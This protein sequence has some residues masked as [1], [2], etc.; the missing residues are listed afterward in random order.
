MPDGGYAAVY[1]DGVK[2][3]SPIIGALLTPALSWDNVQAMALAFNQAGSTDPDKVKA[4]FENL[5]LPADADLRFVAFKR[6]RFSP[7]D[8]FTNQVGPENFTVVPLGPRVDG[9][10]KQ[11]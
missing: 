9:A 3:T 1:L 5:R 2:K 7:T 4:A 11:P 8:H 10:Y 6:V